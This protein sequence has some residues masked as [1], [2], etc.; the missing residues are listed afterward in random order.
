[1]EQLAQLH[2]LT[3]VLAGGLAHRQSRFG[4]FRLAQ[5]LFPYMEQRGKGVLP[6]ADLR[7]NAALMVLESA[8]L[9]RQQLRLRDAPAW[10]FVNLPMDASSSSEIR[11]RGDWRRSPSWEWRSSSAGC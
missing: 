1:M 8:A 2:A 9:R 10:C 11:A 4:L 7:T 5:V 3:F 6:Q